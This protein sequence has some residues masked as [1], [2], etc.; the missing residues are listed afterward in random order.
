LAFIFADACAGL[1]AYGLNI[2]GISVDG[3]E[4][5][6]ELRPPFE[7]ALPEQVSDGEHL[8]FQQLYLPL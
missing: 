6:Y 5:T 2:K 3:L 1:H 4:A 7:E 8:I